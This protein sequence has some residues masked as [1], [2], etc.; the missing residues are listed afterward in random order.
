MNVQ[1]DTELVDDIDLIDYG[2][3]IHETLQSPG[4]V[5]WDNWYGLG[6]WHFDD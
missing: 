5:T 3:A 1:T 6:P 2:D 4:Y